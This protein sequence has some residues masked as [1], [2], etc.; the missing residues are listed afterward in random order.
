MSYVGIANRPPSEKETCELWISQ[1]GNEDI[2]SPSGAAQEAIPVGPVA[3]TP[4][5]WQGPGHGA[6]VSLGYWTASPVCFGEWPLHW[7]WCPS[8]AWCGRARTSEEDLHHGKLVHMACCM[9]ALGNYDGDK[10][11]RGGRW[12]LRFSQGGPK[13][14]SG[15]SIGVRRQ[16][17][18]HGC[19]AGAVYMLWSLSFP[20]L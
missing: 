7:H 4:V 19:Q 20:R 15:S 18:L 9:A 1:F 11:T 13:T 3:S 10:F 8:E 16:G 2:Y 17:N 14:S 6:N 5:A 12:R